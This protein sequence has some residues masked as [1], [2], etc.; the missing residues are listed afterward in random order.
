[1]TFGE[2]LIAARE[3]AGLTQKELAAL[4]GIHYRTIQNWELAGKLPNK[5]DMVYKVAQI[6]GTTPDALMNPSD[7]YVVEASEKGGAKAAREVDTLVSGVIGLFAGGEIDEEEKDGIMAALNEAYWK[8]KEK[9][10]KY[11]PKKYQK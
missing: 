3:K 11:T 10:K 4:L 6:L 7:Q 9:N 5:L 2:N 1:M 8:S